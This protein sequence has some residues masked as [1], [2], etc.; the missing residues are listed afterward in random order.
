MSSVRMPAACALLV[1][2]RLF[3]SKREYWH[4]RVDELAV[5]IKYLQEI[6]ASASR[7]SAPLDLKSAYGDRG[8]SGLG[9]EAGSVAA[10][11]SAGNFTEACPNQA[12]GTDL[13]VSVKPPASFAEKSALARNMVHKLTGLRERANWVGPTYPYP[14]ISILFIHTCAASILH[15]ST[16]IALRVAPARASDPP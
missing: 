9:L 1:E 15:N 11:L 13:A 10:D 5:A 2:V 8:V 6:G 4:G 7:L 14:Y 12:L 3:Y 16:T